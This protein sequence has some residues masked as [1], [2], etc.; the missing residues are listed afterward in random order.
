MSENNET[1][2]LVKHNAG[3]N[4]S[5]ES[6]GKENNSAI[7]DAN[8][9]DK[10]DIFQWQF[11]ENVKRDSFGFILRTDPLP[12]NSEKQKKSESHDINN[13]TGK[14]KSDKKNEKGKSDDRYDD[15]K[16]TDRDRGRDRDRDKG[17]DRDRSPHG[18]KRKYSRSPSPRRSRHR[19]SRS[20]SRTPRDPRL[21]RN[22]GNATD[23]EKYRY[24]RY[25]SEK[26]PDKDSDKSEVRSSS[27]RRERSRSP[28]GWRVSHNR[29]GPVDPRNPPMNMNSR[30]ADYVPMIQ[31][32]H[33]VPP[34]QVPPPSSSSPGSL[35]SVTDCN[36][37]NRYP[38]NN[39]PPVPAP[40][41]QY[42]YPHAPGTAAPETYQVYDSY[43][44]GYPPPPH[45]QQPEY[46][47][48]RTNN[49]QRDINPPPKVPPP[50]PI[51]A[52]DPAKK[53]AIEKELLQQKITLSKQ[54]DEYLRKG[55]ILNRELEL[56]KEQKKE[57][58]GDKTRDSEKLL[59]E[60]NKLQLEIGSKIKA[61][62]N[63]IDIL[64][65]I[66]GD[67]RPTIPLEEKSDGGKISGQDSSKEKEKCMSRE[68][69]DK[70][71]GEKRSKDSSGSEDQSSS[72]GSSSD[73]NSE[74]RKKARK[75]KKKKRKTE[76]NDEN[77]ASRT[78]SSMT[79]ETRNED[80]KPLCNFIYYDPE[81]HW[82]QVCDEFPRTAKE[83]LNHLHSR[84][85][86]ELT[87]EKKLNDM[88]W[89][90][91]N[92]HEEIPFYDGAP[93]KRIPIKGLQFLVS[94]T[95]WFCKLCRVWIGDLH[96]ASLHLKS[97]DH[98]AN[99]S[100]FSEQNPHWETDWMA[101]REKAYEK[102]A[103]LKRRQRD[104]EL[105]QKQKQERMELMKKQEEELKQKFYTSLIKPES[106]ETEL[107]MPL[108]LPRSFEGSMIPLKENLD[109]K[110]E[111]K[112]KAKKE[113][114]KKEKRMKEK[115][116]K[117]KEK[118]SRKSSSSD[119]G[120]S[121]ESTSESSDSEDEKK[122]KKEIL[123]DLEGRSKSMRAALRSK[124][125]PED[126][127]PVTIPITL[128][129]KSKWEMEE[130]LEN[131]PALPPPPPEP[132]EVPQV[133]EQHTRSESVDEKNVTKEW[134]KTEV[135]P[136][137][138]SS[139]SAK[140]KVK[141]K[142]RQKDWN[143]NDDDRSSRYD[144]KRSYRDKRQESSTS[145]RERRS[146]WDRKKDYRSSRHSRRS[147]TRS[148]SRS[149]SRER[150][151][152]KVTPGVIPAPLYD[153]FK[154]PEK[155][156]T[157][158][159]DNSRYERSDDRIPETDDGE[160]KFEKQAMEAAKKKKVQPVVNIPKSKFGFIGRMPFAKKRSDSDKGRKD[161]DSPKKEDSAE[162]EAPPPPRITQPR[163][164]SPKAPKPVLTTKT[165]VETAKEIVSKYQKAFQ[166]K[167]EEPVLM[168]V[169]LAPVNL[170]PVNPPMVPLNPPLPPS[171]PVLAM[172]MSPPSPPK[173]KDSPKS[174]KKSKKSPYPLPKDF[175][176]ALSI[177]Y[178][179]EKP[180]DKTEG[181]HNAEMMAALSFQPPMGYGA[182]MMMAYPGM[183]MMAAMPQMAPPPHMMNANAMRMF[184]QTAPPPPSNE[185]SR[186]TPSPVMPP[187]PE[188]LFETSFGLGSS[189]GTGIPGL[190]DD[191]METSSKMSDDDMALL[192]IDAE[193]M[194]AQQL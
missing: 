13:S 94:A 139:R 81:M 101:N 140:E 137:K 161:D 25:S 32:F 3:V 136:E 11:S 21:R 49:W 88:P 165:K 65:G 16:R 86:K 39:A 31:S 37:F 57:L 163:P 128:P 126:E 155:H 9:G 4:F 56:L 105:L 96:C 62:D 63:V 51:P 169:E 119:T 153:L 41:P 109:G 144:K 187:P 118:K 145:R 30:P 147:R 61:V 170:T 5:T 90:D 91:L 99:Y 64:T 76:G 8:Q 89:H 36:A 20:R 120:S 60:N 141:S 50:A 70:K 98:S 122:F 111:K 159:P 28:S 43:Y 184:N 2:N 185:P 74:Y 125:K 14:S 55:I 160:S 154:L 46:I 134:V 100:S 149:N 15:E 114:K 33:P 164:P 176:D 77:L 112:K 38:P 190:D 186:D 175:Q 168:P 177:I 142:E 156:S 166:E 110:K 6:K 132:K 143:K 174:P 152:E 23:R 117:S 191:K 127:R 75:S 59:K 18:Y 10:K 19:R 167:V 85:H 131:K 29:T 148:R 188:N 72:E 67:T 45:P 179:E 58:V 115:K 92:I 26:S 130:V 151:R 52:E 138:D 178:P 180:D 181:Y 173:V 1:E 183:H 171:P 97:K 66:I 53:E 42:S 135:A 116:K 79:M 129:E 107:I 102:C 104:E 87:Q 103:E 150:D 193:D 24:R 182:Q 73:S 95:A 54:R 47:G 108:T 121:S 192:G 17:R 12:L 146:S 157:S 106:T 48:G 69:S 34:N 80:S 93:T 35:P 162:L 71:K 40:P 78:E 7:L 124:E 44:S 84:E 189:N 83:Y 172:S 27:P 68:R 113:K 82:C 123:A 22:A 133:R 158:T 194:A